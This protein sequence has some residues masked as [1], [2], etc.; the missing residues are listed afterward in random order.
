MYVCSYMRV[1]KYTAMYRKIVKDGLDIEGEDYLDDKSQYRFYD[2]SI[3]KMFDFISTY[4]LPRVRNLDYEFDWL[5]SFFVECKKVNPQAVKYAGD[6][7][8]LRS[9]QLQRIKAFFYVI[10]VENDLEKAQDLV[11][12]FLCFFEELQPKFDEL[13]KGLLRLYIN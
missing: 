8:Q 1:Y 6:F 2:S 9:S 11:D 13:H 12:D 7:D 3:Q 4:M 5:Y 10:F